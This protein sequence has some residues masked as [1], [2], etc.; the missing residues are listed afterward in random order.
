VFFCCCLN[1][2]LAWGIESEFWTDGMTSSSTWNWSDQPITWYF[3][4]SD[5]VFDGNGS[6]Y[7][8]IYSST[9]KTYQIVDE[10]SN[11]ISHFICEYQGKMSFFFFFVIERKLRF[12]RAMFDE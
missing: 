7:R 5:R 2:C 12:V 10:M 9:Q 8:M 6:N 4:A 1:E 3:N 11:K